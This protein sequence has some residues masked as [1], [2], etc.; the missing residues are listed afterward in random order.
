[1]QYLT[2]YEFI[3]KLNDEVP[4][5]SGRPRPTQMAYNYLK[6]GRI[7]GKLV[8][9]QIKISEAEY[10]AFVTAYKARNGIK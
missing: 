8:D 6:A 7:T 1:M 3:K 2:G 9:G 4:T 10:K 5:K